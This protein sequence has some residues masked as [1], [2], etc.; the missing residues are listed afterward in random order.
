[1][2]RGNNSSTFI[3][4][5]MGKSSATLRRVTG[6]T[7]QCQ[8]SL[9]KNDRL[10]S[11]EICRRRTGLLLIGR[12]SYQKS[13]E[14]FIQSFRAARRVCIQQWRPVWLNRIFIFTCTGSFIKVTIGELSKKHC[15]LLIATYIY[16]RK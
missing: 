3:R 7:Q 15:E 16:T 2:E 6:S 1:M 5:R 14:K 10:C 12:T 8:A 13:M 9:M 4:S 11:M